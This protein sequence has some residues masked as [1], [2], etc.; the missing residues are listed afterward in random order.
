MI[1]LLPEEVAGLI[2]TLFNAIDVK[3]VSKLRLLRPIDTVPYRQ[4][5]GKLFSSLRAM[6]EGPEWLVMRWCVSDCIAGPTVPVHEHCSIASLTSEQ[7][8]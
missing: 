6:G 4:W 2:F 3:Q 5:D 8:N 1:C 7:C